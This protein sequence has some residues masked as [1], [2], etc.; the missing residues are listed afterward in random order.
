M[1]QASAKKVYAAKVCKGYLGIAEDGCNAAFDL[2]IDNMKRGYEALAP[3]DTISEV[4]K[5][6]ETPAMPE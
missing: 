6:A 3:S 2:L 5:T 1:T 4:P